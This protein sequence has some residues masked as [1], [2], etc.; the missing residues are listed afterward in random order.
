MNDFIKLNRFE[1][2]SFLFNNSYLVED[3]I[4]VGTRGW[5]TSDYKSEVDYKVL[6]RECIRLEASIKNA[7]SNFGNNHEFIVVMHYPPFY[8]EEVNEEIDFI[9]IFKKYEIKKCY[10]GHLHGESIKEAKEGNLERNRI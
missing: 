7:I 4:I 1:N 6:K 8:K 5:V 9:N 3:K 2:I 10:Y